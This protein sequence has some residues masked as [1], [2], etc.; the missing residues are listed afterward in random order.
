ME[1]K[2]ASAVQVSALQK[3]NKNT[4]PTTNPPHHQKLT[5]QPQGGGVP[6]I[7]P[8]LANGFHRGPGGQAPVN[9]PLPGRGAGV[10]LHVGLAGQGRRQGGVE[11]VVGREVDLEVWI[12]VVECCVC[13]SE[14]TTGGGGW[15]WW[16]GR[17]AG[18]ARAPGR[19]GRA[20]WLFVGEIAA[21]G[22]NPPRLLTG[23]PPAPDL[24]PSLRRRGEVSH[25]S[26]P[27]APPACRAKSQDPRGQTAAVCRNWPNDT[28]SRTHTHA[29]LGPRARRN[30]HQ[31]LARR[32]QGG[33]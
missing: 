16:E 10:A 1:A 32:R 5:Q 8:D 4:T 11:G 33:R 22:R 27:H 30:V 2:R 7:E 15:V 9:G 21:P 24:P 26:P 29:H 23:S 13:V 14:K 20:A 19:G 28:A 17:V 6:G 25:R 12:R 18:Q 31:F 3:T